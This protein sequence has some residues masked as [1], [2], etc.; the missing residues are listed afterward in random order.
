MKESLSDIKTEV[1]KSTKSSLVQTKPTAKGAA[2]PPEKSSSDDTFTTSMLKL[3][4]ASSMQDV[5]SKR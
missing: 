5:L 1:S 2:P 4:H 3:K